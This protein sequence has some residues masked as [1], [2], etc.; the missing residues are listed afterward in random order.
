MRFRDLPQFIQ[1][2]KYRCDVPL[3]YIPEKIQDWVENFNLV[4]CPDF[5]RGHVWTEAQ[6][7][8]F[9]EYILKGGKTGRELQFNHPGWMKTMTKGEFVCVDG[10]QRLTAIIR[11][12]KDEIP[13]F[14]YY[15]RDFTENVEITQ[16]MS[17]NVNDLQ[18]REDV[19][20]WYLEMN[21]TGTPHTPEELARVRKLLEE[22]KS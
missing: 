10:L 3:R 14:G 15:L 21:Y 12:F 2:P 5:Q 16:C 11:F 8:A 1:S 9:M 18:T 4:L 22:E 13:V 6:Q 19:I 20:S 7:I 17:F